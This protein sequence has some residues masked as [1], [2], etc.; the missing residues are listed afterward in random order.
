MWHFSGAMATDMSNQDRRSAV[1]KN[2]DPACTSRAD[3][4]H[5]QMV[6]RITDSIIND[7]QFI[8]P[9]RIKVIDSTR[10]KETSEDKAKSTSEGISIVADG[11]TYTTKGRGATSKLLKEGVHQGL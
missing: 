10:Y 5:R 8:L 1:E 9:T 7:A 4:S 11:T 3:F 2:T 6:E